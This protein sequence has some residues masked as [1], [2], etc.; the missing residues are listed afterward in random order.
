MGL[1]QLLFVFHPEIPS[2]SFFHS[3]LCAG[4]EVVILSVCFQQQEKGAVRGKRIENLPG[5]NL[6]LCHNSSAN[7]IN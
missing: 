4:F 7:L 6:L 1:S 3:V 5:I 2:L